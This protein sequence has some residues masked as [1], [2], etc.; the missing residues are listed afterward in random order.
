[1]KGTKQFTT[2][3]MGISAGDQIINNVKAG[4]ADTDAVNVSQ[5]K[6]VQDQIRSI[7]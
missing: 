5:L 6:R 3:Q 1:M 2:L 4:V 7:Y